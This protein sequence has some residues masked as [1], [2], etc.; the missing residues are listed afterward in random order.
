MAPRLY[1]HKSND[2]EALAP[3]ER[4]WPNRKQFHW[5]LVTWY[6]GNILTNF[7]ALSY[8]LTVRIF[9]GEVRASKRLAA[10][11][12]GGGAAG[13]GEKCTEQLLQTTVQLIRLLSTL[14][15]GNCSSKTKLLGNAFSNGRNSK[16]AV[17]ALWIENILKTGWDRGAFPK[18]WQPRSQGLSSYR[19]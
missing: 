7:F 5:V 11:K 10:R 13:E 18:R 4:K 19:L 16:N 15:R 8:E 17:F 3:T 9:R 6:L 2:I 14:N 12:S 1:S